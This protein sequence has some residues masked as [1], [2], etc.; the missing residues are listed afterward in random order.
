MNFLIIGII[1]LALA[2]FYLFTIMPRMLKRPDKTPFEGWLYAHRGLFDNHTN[3][4]ENSLPAFQKAVEAGFGIELDV[5]LTKD[6]VP[7]VFHDFTLER[8]CKTKGRVNEFTY[9]ELKKLKLFRS[10]QYI[11]TLEEALSLIDGQTPII[12]ELKIEWSD[13]SVCPLADKLLKQYKGAYAVESFNPLGLIWYRRNRSEVVRGQLSDHF[14]KEGTAKGPFYFLLHYL[15][16]NFITKPDF[17]AYN[18]KYAK[19]MSRQL[20]RYLYGAAAAGW[21]IKSE[22]QLKQ[23]KDNFDW[24][25]FD[26]FVPQNGKHKKRGQDGEQAGR[27]A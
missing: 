3:A 23:A 5:Q 18:H 22:E 25:I 20:C 4:P 12:V 9:K 19:N 10:E 8:A 11:P 24:F 13:Y 27:T 17:I 7:V 26:G 1:V 16:L 2:A 15:T 6:K 21:T 14:R